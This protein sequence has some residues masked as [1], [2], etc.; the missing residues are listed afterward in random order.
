MSIY[1]CQYMIDL[2]TRKTTLKFQNTNQKWQFTFDNLEP[3]STQLNGAI[4][5][6]D[7]GFR[8]MNPRFPECVGPGFKINYQDT[9]YT[10]SPLIQKTIGNSDLLEGINLSNESVITFRNPTTSKI[11]QRIETDG[12][13]LIRAPPLS[14]KTSAGQVDGLSS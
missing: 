5:Y 11:Y 10:M 8:L 2:S 14:G 13:T 12:I 7:E 6:N 9:Q 3:L 4:I 1:L